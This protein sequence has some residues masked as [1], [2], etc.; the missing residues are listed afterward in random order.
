MNRLTYNTVTGRVHYEVNKY[1]ASFG[2]G[3]STYTITHSLNSADIQV[4]IRSN[5]TGQ[6]YYPSITAGSPPQY[7]AIV[8]DANSVQIDFT[9]GIS[10]NSYTIVVS[11]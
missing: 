3:S 4:N 5:S 1:K 7:T 9:S 11:K 10:A 8:V 6:I 2:D